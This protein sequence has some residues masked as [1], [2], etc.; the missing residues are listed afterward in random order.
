M[1]GRLGI[2]TELILQTC[3]S[4]FKDCVWLVSKD[5]SF[6]R[7]LKAQVP[8][9]VKAAVLGYHGSAVAKPEKGSQLRW[10]STPDRSNLCRSKARL[11][12]VFHRNLLLDVQHS[13]NLSPSYNSFLTLAVL[14]AA[15]LAADSAAK[16]P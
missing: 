11:R 13:F 1:L 12:P 7:L 16:E 10:S 2:S 8:F 15:L 3:S 4:E 14:A 5:F 6:I 9:A